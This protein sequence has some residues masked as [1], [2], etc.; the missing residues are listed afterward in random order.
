MEVEGQLT[1]RFVITVQLLMAVSACLIQII[2]AFVRQNSS[3]HHIVAVCAFDLDLQVLPPPLSL[4]TPTG[5]TQQGRWHILTETSMMFHLN[6][7]LAVSL[8]FKWPFTLVVIRVLLALHGNCSV[9]GIW[10][11]QTE[12]SAREKKARKQIKRSL[13]I[14]CVCVSVSVLT[15]TDMD[16][17]L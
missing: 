1:Q 8:L 13:L 10:I 9:K 4:P 14:R 5:E 2:W 11:Q 16:E 12:N 17:L 7:I 3:S 15:S 6:N